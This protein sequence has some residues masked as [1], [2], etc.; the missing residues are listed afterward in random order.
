M[1][2]RH[3]FFS[4]QNIVPIL[5]FS[6]KWAG[7]AVSNTYTKFAPVYVHR[8][9]CN[10]LK[11]SFHESISPIP[12]LQGERL[13]NFADTPHTLFCPIASTFIKCLFWSFAFAS[14]PLTVPSQAFLHFTATTRKDFAG[15]GWCLGAVPSKFSKSST[16]LPNSGEGQ[17]N[18]P[19]KLNVFSKLYVSPCLFQITAGADELA[20]TV[21]LTARERR[22]IKF[23]SVEFGGQLYMTPQDFLESVT[24]AEPRRKE[25]ILYIYKITPDIFERGEFFCKLGNVFF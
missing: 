5:P 11:T 19:Q 17:S 24:E 12:V 6:A 10:H 8:C 4:F 13:Y 7:A 18:D 3:H 14:F 23:S 20:R 2:E 15:R 16:C 9:T 22:F 1:A 21:K 25:E